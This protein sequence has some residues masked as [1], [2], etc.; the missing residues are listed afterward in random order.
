MLFTRVVN[1]RV[2]LQ[3]AQMLS[4]YFSH[5]QDCL[6]VAVEFVVHGLDGDFGVGHSQVRAFVRD[7]AVAFA[8]QADLPIV[9]RQAADDVVVLDPGRSLG[10]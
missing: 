10:R 9:V 3:L 2:A 8:E 7:D 5:L 4:Q 6:G 1:L